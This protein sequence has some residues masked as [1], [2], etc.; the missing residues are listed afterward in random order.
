ML[1]HWPKYSGGLHIGGQVV[2]WEPDTNQEVRAGAE[3]E[4]KYLWKPIESMLNKYRIK[5]ESTGYS[6][7]GEVIKRITFWSGEYNSNDVVNE[8]TAVINRYVRVKR[9]GKYH[10][11]FITVGVNKRDLVDGV[12]YSGTGSYMVYPKG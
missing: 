1:K 10:F 11:F 5:Y 9:V 3:T 8:I 4:K 2:Y 7:E 12:Y 6:E